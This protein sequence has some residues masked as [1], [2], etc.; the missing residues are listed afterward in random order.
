MKIGILTFHAAKNYGAVLQCRCLYE[1]LKSLGHDV[2]VIDYRPDYL[3]EPYRL[4]K[5][6]FLKHPGSLI[7]A[8]VKMAGAIRR[9]K[10]FDA[11][12][13]ELD[14]SSPDDSSF[15]A[16]FYGSDQIWNDGYASF[17][18]NYLLAFAPPG[19]MK[20]AY[21]PSIGTDPERS[22][23]LREEPYRHWL[24][25]FDH[26]SVRETGQR[27]FVESMSGKVCEVVVDPTLL[28]DRTD[29][30]A[31]LPE[32]EKEGG[33]LL[34]FWLDHDNKL[35]QGIDFA[36]SV[37]L[38]QGLNIVHC[39][40]KVPDSLMVNCAGSIYYGG[41]EDFLR[42]VRNADLVVTNSYHATIFSMIFRKPFYTF[43]VDSMRSRI[44]TLKELYGIGDRCVDGFLSP[45]SV[46]LDVDYGTIW[47]NIEARREESFCYLRGIFR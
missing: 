26:L 36:N 41:V 27:A 33:Y 5:S 2:S 42:Y 4:W 13:K 20:V 29:Y 19:A 11:F 3:T 38:A 46:S 17:S 45:D 1:V 7:K 34:L 14:L 23:R 8:S 15:D 22:D 40:Q 39:F 25:E 44:D 32:R 18:E 21:A 12:E 35:M 43:T 10:A 24:P 31:L 16:I 30:E 28:L 37:A 6:S 47:R 9:D